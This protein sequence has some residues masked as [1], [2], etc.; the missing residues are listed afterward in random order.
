MYDRGITSGRNIANVKALAWE[1]VCGVSLTASV[2]KFRRP[3]VRKSDHLPL[4]DWIALNQTTFYVT[5]RPYAMQQV[6]GTPQ[7]IL[8]LE[9]KN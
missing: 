7:I 5:A 4:S 2:Q 6:K 9:M 3:V 8:E 1:T